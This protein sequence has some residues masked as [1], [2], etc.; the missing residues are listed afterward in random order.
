L[1]KP[2]APAIN[3]FV[4]PVRVL[5]RDDGCGTVLRKVNSSREDAMARR[6]QGMSKVVTI[7]T[8]AMTL[9]D[10]ARSTGP[11]HS[12]VAARAYELYCERGC[13]HGHEVDDWLQAERELRQDA[14]AAA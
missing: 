12:E 6:R 3:R 5:Y 7:P 10:V 13:S 2:E 14:S 4:Y 1:L 11:T 8:A 9:G